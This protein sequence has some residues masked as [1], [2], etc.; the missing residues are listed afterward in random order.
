MKEEKKIFLKK[1]TIFLIVLFLLILLINHL[2]IK[3]I[4][5]KK[6]I[7]RKEKE[8]QEYKKHLPNNTLMHG[9]F[10]D[11]HTRNSINPRHIN[12]SFNF[13]TSAED[14]TETYYKF[15]GI[16]NEGI[17]IQNVFLEIDLHTFSTELR[18]K[19]RLFEETSYYNKKIPLKT[20]SN[21]RNESI[22]NL[23]LK[24]KIPIFGKGNEIIKYLF[25]K[26]LTNIYLGWTKSTEDFSKKNKNLLAS[27][28]FN[29]HF[30]ENKNL[31][32]KNSLESFI[33]ILNIS[34]KEGINIILIRY[35]VSKE[36]NDEIIN[37]NISINEYYEKLFNKINKS[38]NNYTILNYYS[39][40]FNNSDYFSNS[41]HLNNK[42][43]KNLSIMLQNDLIELKKQKTIQ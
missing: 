14:Y 22:I 39:I 1:G 36:Y 26:K 28:K 29:V 34:K 38:C 7:F 31:F 16:L 10:G 32:E 20:I 5:E 42:G 33:K 24:S 19:E 18:K 12:Y 30:N 6:Q 13:G 4:Y 21:L 2:Y 11:S 40:Y 3:N 23:F 17:T 15:Q 35:P 27:E 8:W 37:N 25:N 9:F 41:D 43:S